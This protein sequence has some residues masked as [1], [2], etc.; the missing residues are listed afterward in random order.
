VKRQPTRIN[1]DAEQAEKQGWPH[2]MLKEIN[3]QPKV[4]EGIFSH[5]I[6]KDKDEVYFEKLEIA[7]EFL[8]P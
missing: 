2:F 5:R 3:E 8:A 1:W 4:L 6:R 7:D